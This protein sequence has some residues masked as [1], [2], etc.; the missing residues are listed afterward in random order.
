MFNRI[1]LTSSSDKP[2]ECV[3]RIKI[4]IGV[5][6]N[7]IGYQL[8]GYGSCEVLEGNF[9]AENILDAN[10]IYAC[11]D[12]GFLFYF[13]LYNTTATISSCENETNGAY[14]RLVKLTGTDLDYVYYA[15]SSG[16]FNGLS[17]GQECIIA[18]YA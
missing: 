6:E 5:K 3:L 15:P 12:S 9:Q 11:F 8:N 10:C 13:F 7:D 2:R 17:P 16:V 1:L 14:L 4:S 18:F